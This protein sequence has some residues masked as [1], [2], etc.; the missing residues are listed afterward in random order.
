MFGLV[1]LFSWWWIIFAVIAYAIC[2]V[3]ATAIADDNYHQLSRASEIR[4]TISWFYVCAV[5][6]NI[7]TLLGGLLGAQGSNIVGGKDLS[8]KAFASMRGLAFGTPYPIIPAGATAPTRTAYVNG[9]TFTKMTPDDFKKNHKVTF[10]FNSSSASDLMTIPSEKIVLKRQ[11][12]MKSAG[13]VNFVYDTEQDNSSRSYSFY[14]SIQTKAS[15]CKV[16]IQTA[17]LTTICTIKEEPPVI[18]ADGIKQGAQLL[19]N[20]GVGQVVVTVSPALY[21]QLSGE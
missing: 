20:N 15:D 6:L 16:V 17:Y 3:I 11:P 4:Q 7:I 10:Y 18:S 14:G 19:V 13:T 5:V 1:Y 12:G 8:P 2:V 9:G 21:A